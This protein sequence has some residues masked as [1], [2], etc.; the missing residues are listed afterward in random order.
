[1]L[2]FRILGLV[3]ESLPGSLGQKDFIGGFIM[4]LHCGLRNPKL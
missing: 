4:V 2:R 1:M 3:F